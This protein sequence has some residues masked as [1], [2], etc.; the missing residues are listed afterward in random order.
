MLLSFKEVTPDSALD[1]LCSTL[2]SLVVIKVGQY[3]IDSDI[4]LSEYPFHDESK[5]HEFFEAFSQYANPLWSS[6]VGMN[7]DFSKIPFRKSSPMLDGV[8]KIL[9]TG[10]ARNETHHMDEALRIEETLRIAFQKGAPSLLIFAVAHYKLSNENSDSG[11][12]VSLG[13]LGEISPF[14][15]Q[16]GWDDLIF[17]INPK[18]KT[19]Y[20]IACTDSD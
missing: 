5:Y 2:K 19:L 9:R 11:F 3:R 18:Y 14:F 8:Y 1:E 12:V 15:E 17:I 20:V 4:P 13:N 10:G 7:W 16:L 6:R